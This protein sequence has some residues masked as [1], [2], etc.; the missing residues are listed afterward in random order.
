MI[1]QKDPAWSNIG[2]SLATVD[3]GGASRQV[4]QARLRGRNGQRLLV[5]QWN[6]INQH[7]TVNDHVAKLVLAL[8]RVRLQ[9]DDGLSVLVATPYEESEHETAAATLARFAADMEPSIGRALDQVD[10]Q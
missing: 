6:L 7:P 10:G 9:R 1:R 8:D 5:W 3:I 2:E 4:R